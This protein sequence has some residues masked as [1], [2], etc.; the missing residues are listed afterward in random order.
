[1]RK[2]YLLTNSFPYGTGEKSFILPELDYLKK[3]FDITILSF[4]T[5]KEKNNIEL[6][7]VLSDNIK[8]KHLRKEINLIKKIILF[9]VAHFHIEL[10][11]EY[12]RIFHSRKNRIK[13]MYAA[14][15][16]YV[17]GLYFYS[18]LK[19][20]SL[21]Y[22]EGT[23]FYSY[24]YS[25][26]AL[27][28]VLL[29]RKYPDIRIITRTHRY[30]LYNES[31][32]NGRQSFK[33]YMSSKL[34]GIFFISEEGYNYYKKMFMNGKELVSFH[35]SRLGVLPKNKRNPF[36]QSNV[37]E[38][39]SCSYII[40][41]K[42]VELIIHA[43]SNLE[44][45]KIHWVHFGDGSCMNAIKKLATELLDIKENITYSLLGYVPNSDIMKYYE[46][47]SVDCLISTSSSEGIPVSI[48]EA[49][50]Y[51]IP[52][53]GTDVGG[54]SEAID[55]NGILLSDNPSVQNVADAIK[56]IVSLH[57]EKKVLM[58][59]RSYEIWKDKFNSDENYQAFVK[60][61]TEL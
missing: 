2:L 57:Q 6:Q 8:V 30:D 60:Q 50:S 18:Q 34:N 53:I 15:S 37:F 7:T 38:L 29:K 25:Y 43:L 16:F 24:W 14:I 1:M 42:R 26:Q 9:L 31:T 52:I 10:W 54:V 17:Y 21:D 48:Q 36:N 56:D 61:I 12:G 55:G 49:L 40:P 23:V 22:S 58:R 51:G 47:N 41:V 5:E 33:E 39:V 32:P 27:S 3:E 4:A 35:I 59:D 20:M 28:L 19:K 46:T 13:N 44:N 45:E 11:R